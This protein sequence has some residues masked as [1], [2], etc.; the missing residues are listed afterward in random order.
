MGMDGWVRGQA[1]VMALLIVVFAASIR[2]CKIA[3][4]NGSDSLL[5]KSRRRFGSD[6]GRG[7]ELCRGLTLRNLFRTDLS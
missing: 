7:S 3:C 2:A 6:S 4:N 1:F 5:M